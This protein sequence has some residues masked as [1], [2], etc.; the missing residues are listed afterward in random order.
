MYLRDHVVPVLELAAT[1]RI[2]DFV[3][4]PLGRC[5]LGPTYLVW[6]ATPDL[7][8]AIIWGT[9][10]EPVLRELVALSRYDSH[11]ALALKR[12]VLVDCHAVAHVDADS[13]IQFASLVRDRVALWANTIERHAVIVPAGLPGI[14]IGGAL[15]SVGASHPMRCTLDAESALAYVDHSAARAA[16]QAATRIADARRGHA[17]LISRLH[18]H[19]GRDPGSSTLESTAAALGMSERT[20][21][22]ELAR[23]D[24]SFS[25]ELRRV[26]ISVAESLLIHSDLKIDAIALKVGFGSASRMSATLRRELNVTASALRARV[27]GE[28]PV[29]RSA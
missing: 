10:D 27:R 24:T 19:L 4:A 29:P 2:E 15:P 20:L 3:S 13:M 7:H 5:V 8:G 12:R 26:R 1:D 23:L 28:R 9:L 6:C 18:A 14:L 22:R 16:H 17:L 11:P 21:Q 25:D